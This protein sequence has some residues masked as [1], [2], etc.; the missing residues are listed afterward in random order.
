[1]RPPDQDR[2]AY[3]RDCITLAKIR[4][5]IESCPFL[6]SAERAST[7]EQL[8]AVIDFL[9]RKSARDL[10]NGNG[11]LHKT[12]GKAHKSNGNGKVHQTKNPDAVGAATAHQAKNLDTVGA[13]QGE[14]T[15]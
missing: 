2:A 13:K 9:D 3:S 6:T 4:R 8:R 5:R 7:S 14:K 15:R 11:K 1:M 10:A 12:N